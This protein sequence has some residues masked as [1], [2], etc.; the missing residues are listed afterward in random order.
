VF[1]KVDG[2]LNII[3]SDQVFTVMARPYLL[4]NVSKGW[5]FEKCR[6]QF[7][8]FRYLACLCRLGKSIGFTDDALSTFQLRKEIYTFAPYHEVL[9]AH[10]NFSQ[11]FEI[12]SMLSTIYEETRSG[13]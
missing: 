7:T 12:P 4:D 11:Q 3:E 9:N 10:R 13:K 1:C 8:H 6:L 5:Y 2:E